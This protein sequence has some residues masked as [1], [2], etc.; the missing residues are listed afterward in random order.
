MQ[1][2]MDWP[3]AMQTKERSDF[4]KILAKNFT[5]HSP[6]GFA[7]RAA[8][9]ENRV[10]DPSKVKTAGYDNLV[11][12]L[13]TDHAILTYNNVVEDEPG[14]PTAWKD[15]MTWMDDFVKEDGQWKV[16]SSRMINIITLNN[17]EKRPQ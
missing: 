5:L 3:R 13:F 17:P 9:I 14:G 11:L 15:R 8:Y 1:A 4:E 7:D 2:K 6:E 10:S 16:G 12:Q